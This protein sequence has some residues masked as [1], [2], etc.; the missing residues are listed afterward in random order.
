MMFVFV[1]D[2]L[3]YFFGVDLTREQMEQIQEEKREKKRRPVV[4]KFIYI[5][6]PEDLRPLNNENET[7][8]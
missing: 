1:K 5:N 3:K 2:A 4:E 6:R 8:V 7:S